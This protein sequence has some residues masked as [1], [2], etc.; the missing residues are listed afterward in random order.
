MYWNLLLNHVFRFCFGIQ[1]LAKDKKVRLC[2]GVRF[3]TR[4]GS[5]LFWNSVSKRFDLFLDFA[6]QQKA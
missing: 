5:V 1:F 2:F 4:K 3:S 6:F